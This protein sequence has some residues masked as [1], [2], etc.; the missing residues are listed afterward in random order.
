M[1]INDWD[2]RAQWAKYDE[3]YLEFEDLD[4]IC[5]SPLAHALAFLSNL[6]S[7]VFMIAHAEHERIWLSTDTSTLTW[8]EDEQVKMLIQCG[9]RYCHEQEALYFLV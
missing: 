9:I 2:I 1:S 4:L 3:C 5:P 6:E 7:K 8:L